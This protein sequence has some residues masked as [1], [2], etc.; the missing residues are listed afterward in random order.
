MFGFPGG[1]GNTHG[2]P[3]LEEFQDGDC[4]EGCEGD[5]EDGSREEIDEDQGA[6]EEVEVGLP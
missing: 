6:G 3:L 5:G 1:I 4:Q 2:K